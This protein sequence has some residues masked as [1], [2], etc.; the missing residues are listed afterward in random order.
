MNILITCPR[1]P[2]VLDWI[3]V[4]SGSLKNAGQIVLCDSLRFPLAAFAARRG[5]RLRYCRIPAP[6]TD[7]AAY[8]AAM[9]DLVAQADLVVPT[10]EDIFHLAHVPLPE[11]QREKLFMPLRDLLLGL[12]HKARF[13]DYLPRGAGVC[14]PETRLLESAAEIDFSRLADSVFKPVYSRFG[15]QVKIAPVPSE[16]AALPISAAAPWVQQQRIAGKALCSYAVCERGQVAAQVVYEPMYLINGSA[17]TYFRRIDEPRI[18]AFVAAFAAQNGFH[19]QVAFDFIVSPNHEIYVIECNPRS[20]SGI[21]LL[22]SALSYSDGLWRFERQRIGTAATVSKPLWP[23]F[24]RQVRREKTFAQ[25]RADYAAARDVLADIPAYG[26]ALSTAETAW[27][28][29][30]KG[31]AFTDATTMDIEW[32]GAG[33]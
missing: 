26:T 14:F 4:F 13:F 25:V 21:H 18:E 2:A 29:W 5:A 30:R 7:F 16:T 17:S 33:Q 3:A 10:C 22:A 11:A 15:R 24:A 1:A 28:A 23:L 19:G 9:A 12:H 32:N 8:A 31:I 20:T 27:R 6:R